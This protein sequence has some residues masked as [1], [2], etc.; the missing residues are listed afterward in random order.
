[1]MKG[2]DAIPLGKVVATHGIRGQ[3]RLVLYSGEFSSVAGLDSL[4]LKDDGGSM[5]TFGVAAVTR[6]GK[7]ALVSLKG[8]D[9]INQVLHLVG[10]ELFVR[11]DQLPELEDGE[12]YW[13]DLVGLQVV[14]DRGEHLGKLSDIIVTG[15]NDVYVVKSGEREY[16]IP[17]LAD[18]VLEINPE[19]G[20]M[21]VCPPDGLLDL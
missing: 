1:M 15:S 9:G 20:F 12:Y 10:R 13:C 6:H 18:V 2:S 7:K 4:M 21:K 19:E 16:L 17:A 14:T 5:E 3:L 8:F 11:R